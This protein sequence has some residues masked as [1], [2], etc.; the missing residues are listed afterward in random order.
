MKRDPKEQ[1]ARAQ[2]SLEK[3]RQHMKRVATPEERINMTMEERIVELID[4]EKLR[5]AMVEI[6][7]NQYV[8]ACL[9]LLEFTVGKKQSV[10]S[11][12]GPEVKDAAELMV[13]QMMEQQLKRDRKQIAATEAWMAKLQRDIDAKKQAGGQ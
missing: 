3:Q 7:P 9:R 6:E 4:W 1:L 10:S 13:D 5:A 12:G 11:E 8:N 2:A